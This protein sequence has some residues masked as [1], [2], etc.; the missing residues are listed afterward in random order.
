M[1]ALLA[2]DLPEPAKARASRLF[3]VTCILDAKRGWPAVRIEAAALGV[4]GRTSRAHLRSRI[5]LFLLAWL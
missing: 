3:Q 5:E 2:S 1:Q 4:L